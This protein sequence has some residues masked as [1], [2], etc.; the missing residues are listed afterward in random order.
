[1]NFIQNRI[2]FGIK[3]L[4]FLV[5]ISIVTT[6]TALD[7]DWQG[8]LG[9]IDK[10]DIHHERDST[11]ADWN[12]RQ[13][14]SP[15]IPATKSFSCVT[16]DRYLKYWIRS[17]YGPIQVCTDVIL[18]TDEI[19]GLLDSSG[20]NISSTRF[21]LQCILPNSRRCILDGQGV[22]RMFYGTRAKVAFTGFDFVNGLAEFGG[23]LDISRSN[24]TLIDCNFLRNK[25]DYGGA[26]FM[27]DSTLTLKGRSKFY[28][29]AGAIRGGV[30]YLETTELTAIDGT[31]EFSY[32]SAFD[33]STLYIEFSNVNIKGSKFESNRAEYVSI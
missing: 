16:N 27:M 23:A 5:V 9:R 2:E 33:V 3:P 21:E 32:N 8:R 13:I 24:V 20:I 26:I 31:S 22:S 18:F 14:P 19:G 17:G 1:M 15:P 6:T 29:N 30:M 25:A 28:N 11:I 12:N 4:I 7:T 10:V